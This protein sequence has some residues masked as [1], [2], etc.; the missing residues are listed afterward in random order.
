VAPKITPQQR[1]FFGGRRVEVVSP[2]GYTRRGRISITTGWQPS[3]MLMHRKGDMGSS[4][5]LDEND[6]IVAWIDDKSRR[7]EVNHDKLQVAVYQAQR[8]E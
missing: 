3:L 6:V 4:D 5:L 8:E 7:W 1:Y 2:S